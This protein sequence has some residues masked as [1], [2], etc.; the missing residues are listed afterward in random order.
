M[1]GGAEERAVGY[2]LP[3]PLLFSFL[4]VV[5]QARSL[6][7]QA[8]RPW[9]EVLCMWI[10]RGGG[11]YESGGGKSLWKGIARESAE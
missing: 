3:L 1:G 9:L 6:V 2:I 10:E 8:Q 7:A 4:E 11:W 5:G